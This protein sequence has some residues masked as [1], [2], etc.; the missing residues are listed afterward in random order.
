L[1]PEGND[2]IP[3]YWDVSGDNKVTTVDVLLVIE[4]LN[5]ISDGEGEYAGDALARST[6]T[7]T[8]TI[9]E[10]PSRLLAGVDLLSANTTSSVVFA[11]PVSPSLATPLDRP[12]VERDFG[13]M[14]DRP[15]PRQSAD[16]QNGRPSSDARPSFW[17]PAD[18]DLENTLSEIA[19]E[20]SDVWAQDEDG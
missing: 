2:C 12:A 19:E 8:M 7:S 13:H 20:I 6:Q 9:V 10:E 3:P 14:A 4:F 5:D 15:I 11:G 1:I 18:F 16:T 17:G